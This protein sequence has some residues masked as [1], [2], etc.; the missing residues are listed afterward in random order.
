MAEA[1]DLSNYS[2][3]GPMFPEMYNEIVQTCDVEPDE[4]IPS[5]HNSLAWQ[6]ESHTPQICW[7]LTDCGI[8]LEY[9][10]SLAEDLELS[11]FDPPIQHI[12]IVHADGAVPFRM[13]IGARPGQPHLTLA[14]LVRGLHYALQHI[15]VARQVWD[16]MSVYDRL[17][18]AHAAL[19]RAAPRLAH[20]VVVVVEHYRAAMD[21]ALAQLSQRRVLGRPVDERAA[22]DIFEPG[23]VAELNEL[24][25]RVFVANAE[26]PMTRTTF[27][28]G[29]LL[30]GHTMFMGLQYL[31]PPYY[32]Q[33]KTTTR[34]IARMKRTAWDRRVVDN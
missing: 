13:E 28:G 16:A 11:A 4:D 32:W 24:L 20:P 14:C 7:D 29:D 33:L 26:D 5:L 23:L 27:V 31:G 30:I 19:L 9:H 8:E 2:L 15:R 10:R 17:H 25:T 12:V 6:S 34:N 1:V 3:A 18:V 21:A 22:L